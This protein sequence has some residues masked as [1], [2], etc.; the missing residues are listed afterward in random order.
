M[1]R[2]G[3]KEYGDFLLPLSVMTKG[4][5]SRLIREFEALDAALT[6]RKVRKKVGAADRRTPAKSPQLVELLDLNPVNLDNAAVRSAYSKQLRLLKNN[7]HVMNMTFAAPADAE[8][9][10]RLIAWLRESIHPQTVIEVHLQPSLVA[11]VYLRSQNH[12]FDFSVRS[13]LRARRTDLMQ[14]LE[15]LR[16]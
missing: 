8:S 14:S 6:T 7:V 15:A 11:G 2:T 1:S 13:A 9:L 3:V 5:L 12:V 10:Q 4:D 16:G